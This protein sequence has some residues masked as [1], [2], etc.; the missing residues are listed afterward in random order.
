MTNYKTTAN[1]S[2]RTFT[3]RKYDNNKCY[4]KYRTSQLTPREFHDLLCN[5][6]EDW[7]N[8]VKQEQVNVIK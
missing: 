2:K 1:Y 3:I 6:S 5:T 4:A 8:Y 7:R